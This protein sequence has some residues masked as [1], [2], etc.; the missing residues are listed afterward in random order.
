MHRERSAKGVVQQ[1]T[2]AWKVIMEHVL[3]AGVVIVLTQ[4]LGDWIA[5]TFA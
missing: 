1:G 5:A 2:P 3:M 4:Y